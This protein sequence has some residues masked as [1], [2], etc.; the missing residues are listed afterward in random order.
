V[1]AVLLAFGAAIA[2][3]AV[4]RHLS[5][6]RVLGIGILLAA[7]GVGIVSSTLGASSFQ[8][9]LAFGVAV[10]PAAIALGWVDACGGDG[11]LER[12]GFAAIAVAVFGGLAVSSPITALGGTLFFLVPILLTVAAIVAVG[13]AVPLYLLGAAGA[14]AEPN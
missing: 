3:P 14:T 2:T 8:R 7:V 5:A 6:G 1:G 12:R 11:T 4:R 10:L 13:V 9:F